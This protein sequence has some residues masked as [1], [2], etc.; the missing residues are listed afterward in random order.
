MD[1][2]DLITVDGIQS[3][4]LFNDVFSLDD[5][6]NI[7]FNQK[8]SNIVSKN[9]GYFIDLS[10]KLMCFYILRRIPLT[11]AL[12]FVGMDMQQKHLQIIQLQIGN[13]RSLIIFY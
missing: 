9:F 4:L 3:H 13:Q 11:M 1:T 6:S 5:S 8:K 12:D 7:E 2:T 10:M